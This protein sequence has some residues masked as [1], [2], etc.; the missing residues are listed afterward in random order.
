MVIVTR[1]LQL[2]AGEY[3]SKCI[4]DLFGLFIFR[5]YLVCSYNYGFYKFKKVCELRSHVCK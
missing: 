2:L 4:S 1:T 3:V 5:I